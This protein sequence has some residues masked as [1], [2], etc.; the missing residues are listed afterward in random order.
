M[1]AA[2]AG[3]KLT[4]TTDN[5]VVGGAAPSN[6]EYNSLNTVD[7]RM[8]SGGQGIN[9]VGGQGS[10][11]LI[12]SDST[13]TDAMALNGGSNVTNTGAAVAG[14]YDTLTVSNSAALDRTDL[15]NVS[16]FEGLV[17][18][19]NVTGNT[20]TLIELT[21]AFLAGQHGSPGQCCHFDQ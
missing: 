7:L 1:A 10:D 4:V 2:D 15:A 18:T 8:L 11:R 21:E 6:N 5:I 20:T 14:D 13:F 3:V 17:L 12:L 19:K 16:G 9:F